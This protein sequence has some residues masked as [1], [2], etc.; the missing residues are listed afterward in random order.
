VNLAVGR[1]AGGAVLCF[2]LA[3]A[4]TATAHDVGGAEPR[5]R[6]DPLPRALAGIVVEVHTTLAPQLVVENK[7]R[8]AL[9]VLDEN[10]VPFLRIRP[11]GVEGNF[12]AVALYRSNS[13][14]PTRSSTP[15]GTTPN[16]KL[17]SSNPSWG[18]FD[19]RLRA[20]AAPPAAGAHRHDPVRHWRVPVRIDGVAVA[21]TGTADTSPSPGSW[22]A[23]L[24]SPHEPVAGVH[25]ILLPGR[26]P[27]LFL[28]ASTT[29]NVIVRGRSGEPFLRFDPRGVDANVQSPSWRENALARGEEVA[30]AIDA[31]APPQW[32]TVSSAP[33]YGWV[34]FRAWPGS[35]EPKRHGPAA[36]RWS[37]PLEVGTRKIT[38]EGMT[39][40]KPAAPSQR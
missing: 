40:W 32:K 9:E 8:K 28:E 27:A 7:S 17:L 18:W 21:I 20:A 2:S 25:V 13:P 38:V 5:F 11:G 24:T 33:K 4:A 37:I 29:E 10:G 6:L 26:V 23:R 39:V 12:N 19:E 36:F 16:W 22:Q 3:W 35:D 14:L 31:K 1:Q 15:A 30:M 34:E